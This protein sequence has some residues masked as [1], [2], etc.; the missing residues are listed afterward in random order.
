M[1]E[2]PEGYD[3]YMYLKNGGCIGTWKP[4]LGDAL[5]ET[6]TLLSVDGIIIVK[7]LYSKRGSRMVINRAK[8]LDDYGIYP[9]DD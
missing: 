8:D 7:S 1:I 5:E 3:I 6:K 4:T 9:K 2:D